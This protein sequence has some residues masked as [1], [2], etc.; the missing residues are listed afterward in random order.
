MLQHNKNTQLFNYQLI[1]S[2]RRKTL[3]LQVK[4][5]QVF[6]RAPVYV[7]LAQIEQFI[8]Q[9]SCWLKQKI[10]THQQSQNLVPAFNHHSIVYYLGE[11]KRLDIR[12][13]AKASLDVEGEFIVV[14]LTFKQQKKYQ[15]TAQINTLVRRQLAHFFKEKLQAYLANRLVDFCQKLNLY[16]ENYK[17]RFYKRRWGSCNSRG[18]LSF[19]YLLM[20]TPSWV[21]DYV[22]VH[23][24]CHLQHLNHS[25]NFWA[26]VN[27][28]CA[29]TEQAKQWLKENQ[30]KLIWPQ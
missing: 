7:S 22:I 24:L 23:E 19:N 25:V 16:P 3:L 11:Q 12:Y 2:A 29:Y 14:T 27:K 20:M 6:V 1:R 8:E 26:L 17:V 5:G 13:A 15:S 21:I 28:H 10:A 9:K 30:Y 18:E 4:Q